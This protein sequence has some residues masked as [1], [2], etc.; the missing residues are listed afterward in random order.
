MSI[1]TVKLG[2]DR[3]SERPESFV[4]TEKLALLCHAASVNQQYKHLTQIAAEANLNVVRC[5]G[6][7][8]GIWAEESRLR[9]SG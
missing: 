9:F 7:E 3:F 4:G 1:S 5:F 2:I 6:P 8:H